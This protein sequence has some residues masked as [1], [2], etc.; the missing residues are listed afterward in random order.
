MVC[1][2]TTNEIYFEA[3][4]VTFGKEAQTEVHPVAGMVGGESFS[5][6]S[7]DTD[8]YVWYTV[9]AVGADPA[10][11]GKTGIQVDLATGYTVADAV[12]ETH[13]AV[14]LSKAFYSF[15]GVDLDCLILEGVNIG[16]VNAAAADVDTGFTV[17]ELRVGFSLD[18]GKTKE[19]ITVSFEKEIQTATANQTGSLALAQQ[20]SG[21]T[22]SIEM[23]LVELSAARLNKLIG[24]GYGSSLTPAGG[25]EVIGSGSKKLGESSFNLAGK[26]VLHPIRLDASDKTLDLTFW[27]TVAE[28]SSINYDSQDTKALSLTFNALNDE[29]RPEEVSLYVLQGDSTQYFV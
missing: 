25:T 1:Q 28:A 9:N 27:K 20:L 19:A 23:S 21:E 7:I 10:P 17:T 13:D 22:A 8:Y 6:S 12:S 16:A 24:E 15:K 3:S 14:V 2:T 18:L 4:N 5:I 11:A 26:L 29:T